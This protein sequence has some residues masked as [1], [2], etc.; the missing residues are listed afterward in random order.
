MA[1]AERGLMVID[2]I[3]H[4]ISGHAAREEG[5]SALY[6]AVDDIAKLKKHKFSKNS[7]LLG[8]VK[9]SATVISTENRAHN[10][11]PSTCEWVIDCRINEQYTFQEVLN[12]L[13]A[14]LDAT[15]TPRSMRLKSTMISLDHRLILAGLSMEKTYYGSPT[16]SDKA[17]IP[18]KALKMGPGD[19]AR[20]HTA[21][22]FIYLSEIKKGIEDYINIIIKTI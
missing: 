9:I 7:D 12:E 18:V 11:I 5:E 8:P 15:L 22:E 21:D 10:V 4:G 1:I 14:L 3:N 20:S 17:L 13:T 19:S 6:K 16:T 2:A